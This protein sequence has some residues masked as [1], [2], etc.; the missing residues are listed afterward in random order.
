[1]SPQTLLTASH[2]LVLIGVL[3]AGLGG[4]GTYYYGKKADD[5]KL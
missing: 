5:E 3:S 1:M 2:V 4:F